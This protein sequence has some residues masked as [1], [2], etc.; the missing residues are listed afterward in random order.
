MTRLTV[1]GLFAGVGGIE[2]GLQEAGHHSELLCE[3]DDDAQ[4][5]LQTHFKDT[6]IV[7]DV[8][9]LDELPDVN[10]LAA[11]FPCTDI[12]QA[13][14]KAGISGDQSG[15]VTEI[16]R[17]I[18]SSASKPEWILLE[19]V[20]YLLS[21]DRGRGLLHL[22]EAVEERGY[23]WAYRIVDARAFGLPQRRQRIIFLASLNSDPGKVLFADDVGDQAGFD[24]AVGPVDRGAAYGFYWTEG[25][26]GLGWAAKAV[27]TI[28]GGSG[29][30]IPSPP[31]V[32]TPATD[33]FGT[34]QIQDAERMQ[35][36]PIDWTKPAEVPG[37]RTGSRSGKRWKQVGNA[38]CVPMSTWVGMRLASPGHVDLRG[39]EFVG[40]RWPIAAF[41]FKGRAWRMP[42][43]TQPFAEDFDIQ[44]FLAEPLL[45]LSARAARGFL[46]R[47][48]RSKLRFPEGFLP[49]LRAYIGDMSTASAH[50]LLQ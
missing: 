23:R 7:S 29:L 8:R 26:R 42:V 15:L 40:P 13:G 14:R 48:E 16:W 39:E 30:G 37:E 49:S 41:G 38:V 36:F 47:A 20:S 45:P 5:V 10:V 12:S 17:L 2:K 33:T 32:W 19:N 1:A 18:D 25:L 24:D 46:S 22:I 6:N 4:R 9:Q 27:P 31:A 35:G 43:S 28:K 50:E 21:L 44:Q 11:G 3:L 34:P